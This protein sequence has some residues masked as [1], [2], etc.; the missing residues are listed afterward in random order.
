[1][2]NFVPLR[3]TR[4]T[5]KDFRLNENVKG[6]TGKVYPK[7]GLVDRDG[8]EMFF[9]SSNATTCSPELRGLPSDGGV[10]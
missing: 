5:E 6:K 1:M 3:K 4:D 10:V 7:A 8:I 9:F 2:C